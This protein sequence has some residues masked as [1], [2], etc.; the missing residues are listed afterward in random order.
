M[1]DDAAVISAAAA[2]LFVAALCVLTAQG[3]L[4]PAIPAV[5][6]I[7]SLAAFVMY[8]TDKRAART[9][10]WRTREST[11]HVL[12]LV[13]GWPG[14]LIAQNILRHKS[15]KTSFQVTFWVTVAVN[16]AALVWFREAFGYS[17]AIR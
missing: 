8:R 6:T 9:G 1:V 5:Y 15:R 2:C 12:S 14:A 3:S 17:D 7:A 16:C 10:G 4:T 11:F 13:G